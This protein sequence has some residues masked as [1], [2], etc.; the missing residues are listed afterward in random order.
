VAEKTA[1][2]ALDRKD[3]V[4]PL[5]RGRAERHGF[6]YFRHGTLSLYAEVELWFGKIEWDI[7]A[8]GVFTSV[9]D[10]KCTLMRYI[11]REGAEAL[12]HPIR[13]RGSGLLS[14]K[15]ATR[16]AEASLVESVCRAY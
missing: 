13:R 4:L 3:P 6:E 1:V 15:R 10:L 16:D 7:I 12:R 2:Q 11:Q 5:S 14:M 9:S 8:R